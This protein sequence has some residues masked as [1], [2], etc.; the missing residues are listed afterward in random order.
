MTIV[1]CLIPDCPRPVHAKGACKVHHNQSRAYRV[2]LEDLKDLLSR[3]CQ[4]CGSVGAIHIDHDHSCCPGNARS[5]GNCVRGSLCGPCNHGLGYFRDDPVRLQA[6]IEYL[7]E[8]S[9]NWNKT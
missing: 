7:F 3:P 1:A 4:I 9:V 8:N 6:A 5:C 2:S